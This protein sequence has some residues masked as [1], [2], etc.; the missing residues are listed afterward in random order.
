MIPPSDPR[1]SA[2][3]QGVRHARSVQTLK[4]G[5]AGSS[6]VDHVFRLSET[7]EYLRSL[8][9]HYGA[10]RR[11][12]DRIRDLAVRLQALVRALSETSVV[13]PALGPP[14]LE[15]GPIA[16]VSVSD[17]E[18]AFMRWLT[19]P[20]GADD[21]RLEGPDGSPSPMRHVLDPLCSS[22]RPLPGEVAAALGMPAGT[23]IGHAVSELRLAVDDPTGPRCRSHR[24][25][26]Y[27]L[28]G[29]DRRALV[30]AEVERGSR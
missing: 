3:P 20:V 15:T 25:A 28:R 9:E 22:G 14:P 6:E 4:P 1:T 7:V 8:Q 23:P 27:Y 26:A 19:D 16:Q 29:L 5:E 17:L 12:N 11:L 2:I 24:A 30:T 13:E 21:V 18:A 10:D